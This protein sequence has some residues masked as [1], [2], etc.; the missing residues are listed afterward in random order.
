[1]P[2]HDAALDAATKQ[3]YASAKLFALAFEANGNA[4]DDGSIQTAAGMV[5]QDATA[6][7]A[8]AGAAR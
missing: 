2:T 3:L 7:D 1:M 5:T 6:Y 4:P 8:E